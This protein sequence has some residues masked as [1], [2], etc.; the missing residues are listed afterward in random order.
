[1]RDRCWDE[2]TDEHITR[3]TRL[4]LTKIDR[5]NYAPVVVYLIVSGLSANLAL[6]RIEFF[7]VTVGS[8]PRGLDSQT[9]R[10][11]AEQLSQASKS[12]RQLSKQCHFHH[13]SL[14]TS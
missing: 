7:Q 8:H 9:R 11:F 12:G 5:S 1:M 3:L 13:A 14:E 6:E 2:T 10:Y 4:M